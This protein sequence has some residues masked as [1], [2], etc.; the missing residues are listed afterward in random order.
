MIQEVNRYSEEDQKVRSLLNRKEKMK[1]SI[2]RSENKIKQSMHGIGHIIGS[3]GFKN[4]K[5]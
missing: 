1:D 5:Y 3:K 2:L 4:S